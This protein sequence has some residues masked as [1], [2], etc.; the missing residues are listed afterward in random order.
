ML[1]KKI[2]QWL[3]ISWRIKL[4]IDVH[5]RHNMYEMSMDQAQTPVEQKPF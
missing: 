1:H 2:N 4:S 3:N 5:D